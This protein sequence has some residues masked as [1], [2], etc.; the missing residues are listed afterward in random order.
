MAMS[1]KNKR[2]V[3]TATRKSHYALRTN[4]K[5]NGITPELRLLAAAMVLG[6]QTAEEVGRYFEVSGN[7]V[8]NWVKTLAKAYPGL[9]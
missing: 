4:R 8:R 3:K 7:S 6:G 9:I 5:H 1:T 2:F